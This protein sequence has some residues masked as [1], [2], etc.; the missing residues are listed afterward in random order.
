MP[1][2]SA[3]SSRVSTLNGTPISSKA[4]RTLQTSGKEEDNSLVD[5][6][7]V[8]YLGTHRDHMWLFTQICPVKIMVF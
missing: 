8:L 3:K 6:T 5:T 7:Y 1:A 4:H 2:Q